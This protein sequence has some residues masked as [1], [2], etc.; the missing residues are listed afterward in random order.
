[1]LLNMNPLVPTYEEIEKIINTI[2]FKF[3]KR[4]I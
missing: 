3:P 2:K 4:S 1:M